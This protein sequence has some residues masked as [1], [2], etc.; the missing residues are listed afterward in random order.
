MS[1]DIKRLLI[2]GQANDGPV[3]R[4]YSF[5]VS[6]YNKALSLYSELQRESHILDVSTTGLVLD[7]D[8]WDSSI[9]FV[10]LDSGAYSTVLFT[11]LV[12]TGNSIYFSTAAVTGSLTGYVNYLKV[13]E[14]KD[15]CYAIRQSVVQHSLTPIIE[16]EINTLRVV[17]SDAEKASL[18]LGPLTFKYKYPGTLGNLY[19]ITID[20]DYV[21][22]I[23]SPGSLY[24]N[25]LSYPISNL[26][27]YKRN[28]FLDYSK[29]YMDLKRKI[30]TDAEL[31]EI[32]V[33]IELDN[34]YLNSPV[35]GITV[36]EGTYYLTG[37]TAGSALVAED[38]YRA[39]DN[40]DPSNYEV[41]V[42]PGLQGQEFF[43]YASYLIQDFQGFPFSIVC[44]TTGAN[45]SEVADDLWQSER[46]FLV[47]G[48][49]RI[50]SINRINTDL[51]V[52][53]SVILNSQ[54]SVFGAGSKVRY[55]GYL[56]TSLSEENLYELSDNGV[57]CFSERNNYPVVYSGTTTRKDFPTSAVSILRGVCRK[58]I[59]SLYD[60]IGLTS[61]STLNYA[62]K[63]VKSAIET[64]ILEGS[65]ILNYGAKVSVT[66]TELTVDMEFN[67][68]GVIEKITGIV[69]VPKR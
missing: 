10:Y 45:L 53:Y 57:V 55:N 41:I 60:V 19:K 27:G 30:N 48:K 56:S 63:A 15:L 24:S 21:K 50:N 12:L 6:D 20:S 3:D 39:L 13:P 68:Y 26:S 18:V 40:I 54:N 9:S 51:S 33:Y 23:P 17:S 44:P 43:P 4:T 52:P 32:P 5:N 46:F 47:Q 28:V 67:L 61:T 38:Y 36:Y 16:N 42:C 29:T 8:V 34:S 31:L 2:L 35:S 7:N 58:L 64:S 62:E 11:N 22:I 69:S 66:E 1:V 59:P 25:E 49:G 14:D 37:G 65:P